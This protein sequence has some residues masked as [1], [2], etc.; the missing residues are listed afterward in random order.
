MNPQMQHPQYRG[1]NQGVGRGSPHS[2]PAGSGSGGGRRP[3]M[4][5]QAPAAVSQFAT[6]EGHGW[7][8]EQ[9]RLTRKPTG[10]ELPDGIDEMVPSELTQQYRDLRAYEKKLDATLMRKRLEI[11]DS[12][13]EPHKILKKMR[14]WIHNTVEN[15]PWQQQGLDENAFD[16]DTGVESS[17]RVKM[18]GRLLDDFDD[19]DGDSDSDGADDDDDD[20]DEFEDDD[21][22]KEEGG[23]EDGKKGSDAMDVDGSNRQAVPKKPKTRRDGTQRPAQRKKFSKFFKKIVVE[24]DRPSSV[25][26]DGFTTIEWSKPASFDPSKPPVTADFD[27]FEFERKSDENINVIFKL[28]RD[29]DPPRFQLSRALAQVVD[30]DVGSTAQVLEHIFDYTRHFKLQDDGDPRTIHCDSLLR[31]AF[32]RDTIWF[33]HLPDLLQPHLHPLA[34]LTL[35][36][37]IRVDAAFHAAPQ[38]TI[39]DV[40][41]QSDDPLLARYR[42]FASGSGSSSSS[43]SASGQIPSPLAQLRAI[44]AHDEH[45]ARTMVH[46]RHSMARWHFFSAMADDPVG[47]LRRWM[48][49]QQRDA[50]IVAGD[51][52]RGGGEDALELAWRRG[53]DEGVWGSLQ[54]REAVTL[55]LARADELKAQKSFR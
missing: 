40:L 3:M 11:E 26:P 4:A 33:P 7:R 17:Y 10:L 55:F 49:S 35:Q 48:R 21:D 25:Q 43:L 46:L 44:H 39:Y 42:S 23:P 34:P 53:G 19:G 30:S 52:T 15:Q 20:D 1:Y 13:R 12:Y 38:P 8:E 47:F 29:E 28:F 16:F 45:T 32:N 51:A 27:V 18:E 9:A 24:Y 2:N 31:D 6:Q 41:V 5:G 14:I 50:E 22:E 36:Y 54:A 37:T